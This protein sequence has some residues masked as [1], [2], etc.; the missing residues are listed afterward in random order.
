MQITPQMEQQFIQKVRS[1]NEGEF[2]ALVKLARLRG[3]SDEDIQNGL[4][5]LNGIRGR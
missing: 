5:I 1:M 2:E 3:I 4:G